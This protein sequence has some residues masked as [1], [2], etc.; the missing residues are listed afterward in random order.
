MS[1]FLADLFYLKNFSWISNPVSIF[2]TFF[3]VLIFAS[4]ISKKSSKAWAAFYLASSLGL[5]GLSHH[6]SSTLYYLPGFILL[7]LLTSVLFSL[8]GQS[9]KALFMSTAVFSYFIARYFEST[10]GGLLFLG[11][12][13]LLIKT[14]EV[15][16]SDEP[17][18]LTKLTYMTLWL[19]F[20]GGPIYQFKSFQEDLIRQNREPLVDQI[21]R[22]TIG[23]AKL[24]ILAKVVGLWAVYFKSAEFGFLSK[25]IFVY[26]NLFKI[27][28]Q[29][30]GITDITIA[31]AKAFG[32]HLPENFKNPFSAKDLSDFWSRW[33]MSLTDWLRTNIFFPILANLLRKKVSLFVATAASYSAVCFAMAFLHGVSLT[34]VFYGLWNAVGFIIQDVLSHFLKK[35]SY[36]LMPE[37]F[38]HLLQT[39]VTLTFIGIGFLFMDSID[40]F[41]W[42]VM[43]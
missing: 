30:S 15:I 4:F 14:I 6:D 20:S 8:F 37:R 35:T 13:Y 39:V 38:R 22:A 32:I 34:W 36:V 26:L 18:G 19:P 41:L 42:F 33:H 31:V 29:F 1:V 25:M 2:I 24:L 23:A 10:Q 9:T 28:L 3:L 27:Y 12:G 5:L 40:L 17:F 7:G 16:K 11:L 21:L 43:P